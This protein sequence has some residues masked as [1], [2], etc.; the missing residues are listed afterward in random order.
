MRVIRVL[1]G[2]ALACLAAAATLVLFVY[3]PAEFATL[4]AGMGSDRL[5]EAA[6]FALVVTPHVATF[7]AAPAL[8]GVFI[9]ERRGIADWSY[10]VLVG[11]AIAVLGFLTQHFTETPG[12]ATI[13]HNYALIAFLTAGF[14]GGFTYWL[15]SGHYAAGG[16]TVRAE[17]PAG[18]P[19]PSGDVAARNA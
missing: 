5:S 4:P 6:L 10:Y 16:R 7:A 11:V 15:F 2:F 9:G 3:T 1:F 13:L 17:T 19:P 8:I 18:S 14:I 12:Q